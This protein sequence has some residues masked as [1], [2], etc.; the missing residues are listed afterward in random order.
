MSNSVFVIAVLGLNV[1]LSGIGSDGPL[2]IRV[3]VVGMAFAG[4]ALAGVGP[5][6]RQQP[7]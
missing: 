5:A 4:A 2:G 1:A 3:W 6:R 7:R